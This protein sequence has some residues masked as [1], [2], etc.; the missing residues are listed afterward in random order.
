VKTVK[1]FLEIHGSKHANQKYIR[2]D[3]GGELWT[4]HAFQQMVRDSGYILES[5]TANASFQNS[6]AERPNRTLVDMMR[7]LLRGADLGPEY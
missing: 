2:T 5:T 4:S 3:E 1:K 6:I 7:C